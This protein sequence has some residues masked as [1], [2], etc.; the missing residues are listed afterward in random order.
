MTL[1]I[2][3][4]LAAM[5]LTGM[6]NADVCEPADT[7]VAPEYFTMADGTKF[8]YAMFT[9]NDGS[10][11]R[12]ALCIMQD[13]DWTPAVERSGLYESEL[14]DTYPTPESWADADIRAYNKW[15]EENYGPGAGLTEIQRWVTKIATR[16][17]AYTF[18]PAANQLKL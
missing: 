6:A 15:L 8:M 11:F 4:F 17:S 14:G 12:P 7:F 10:A 18:D 16:Y 13:G 5:A 2:L 3:L 9:I 1:K